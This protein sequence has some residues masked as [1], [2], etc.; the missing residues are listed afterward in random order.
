M[1]LVWCE[2]GISRSCPK[3]HIS[4]FCSCT[5]LTIHP[6]RPWTYTLTLVSA[7][8]HSLLLFNK[9][10]LPEKVQKR[11]SLKSVIWL[12]PLC[13]NLRFCIVIS[14]SWTLLSGAAYNGVTCRGSV[15]WKSWRLDDIEG[16]SFVL[17]LL[18]GVS[19]VQGIIESNLRSFVWFPSLHQVHCDPH[20]NADNLQRDRPTNSWGQYSST[21]EE[22]RITRWIWYHVEKLFIFSSYLLAWQ[23]LWILNIQDL[24]WT[25]LSYKKHLTQLS[26]KYLSTIS[27]ILACCVWRMEGL[28]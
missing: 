28:K 21:N 1:L 4:M 14:S 26:G 6:A 9:P 15:N 20:V 2:H 24:Q 16:D 7:H 11:V 18:F 5:A 27:L 8:E 13:F 23:Y 22:L 19:R 10:T 12:I 17:Y 25:I 3:M